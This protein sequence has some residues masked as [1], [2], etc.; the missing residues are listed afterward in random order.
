MSRIAPLILFDG[1]IR[2]FGYFIFFHRSSRVKFEQTLTEHFSNMLLINTKW[3]NFLL[4]RSSFWPTDSSHICNLWAEILPID[5]LQRQSHNSSQYKEVVL[6]NS[7]RY[8]IKEYFNQMLQT[9]SKGGKE[10]ARNSPAGRAKV[11]ANVYFSFMSYSKNLF[12]HAAF[13]A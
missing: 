1:W 5:C 10:E 12:T 6:C 8:S 7:C 11:Y 3:G 9:R 13:S 4:I 2:L